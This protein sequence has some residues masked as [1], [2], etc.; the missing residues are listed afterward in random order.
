VVLA[1]FLLKS[2]AG[3]IGSIAADRERSDKQIV[4]ADTLSGSKVPGILQMGY[5][6]SVDLSY[7]AAAQDARTPY[8]V[9]G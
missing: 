3:G 4:G 6:V 7:P 1:I 5:V 2:T 8:P 9:P